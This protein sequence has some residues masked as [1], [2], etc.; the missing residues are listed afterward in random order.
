MGLA[1]WIVI[2]VVSLLPLVLVLGTFAA[3][4]TWFAVGQ[5]VPASELDEEIDRFVVEA[6]AMWEPLGF[7][8]VDV[9]HT[10]GWMAH[11]TGW[12]ALFDH[13][14]LPIGALAVR[15]V[16]R[17][18][19][20]ERQEHIAYVASD[21]R[22]ADGDTTEVAT[23]DEPFGGLPVPDGVLVERLPG[24][25]PEELL[26]RHRRR[27]ADLARHGDDAR[28]L[29][30]EPVAAFREDRRRVIEHSVNVGALGRADTD[31]RRHLSW[32]WSVRA[33][34]GVVPPFRQVRLWLARRR[35]AAL[36]AG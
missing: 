10:P 27:L 13:R 20:V 8:F 29:P 15:A 1:G 9:L 22:H 4:A 16:A 26:R 28:G 14:E 35:A 21:V 17:R 5:V 36:L 30:H 25:S 7:D 19:D 11:T 18:G 2:G 23:I 24:R 31:G 33:A 32:S 6:R 12:M 3:K 34:S